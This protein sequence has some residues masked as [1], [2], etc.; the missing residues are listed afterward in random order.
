MPRSA[1]DDDLPPLCNGDRLTQPEFHRRYLATPETFHAELIEGM[2]F[3]MASP[4]SLKKHGGPQGFLIWWLGHYV[5]HTPGLQATGPVTLIVDNENE[6]EPDALLRVARGI[7]GTSNPTEDD[8]LAGI[9]ELVV[10]VAASSA[11]RDLNIKK[12][13]YARIGVPEYIVATTHERAVHWFVLR[14]GAFVELP[15]DDDGVYR[16]P[17]WPGLWL[18]AAAV[19]ADDYTG[20]V[21]GGRGRRGHGGARGARGAAHGRRLAPTVAPRRQPRQ[22]QRPRHRHRRHI[23][24]VPPLP[25]RHVHPAA[26]RIDHRP[27]QR[28]RRP[29]GWVAN[30]A[31]GGRRTRVDRSRCAGR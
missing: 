21:G 16:S 23:V 11:A 30:R 14:D 10:E 27:R 22:R 6:V 13:L 2:V 5:T 17:S 31:L 28:L 1:P 19:W 26:G 12:R 25:P 7:G 8:Y 20:G 18:P 9:P 24:P 3:I 15:A 4:I 29:R